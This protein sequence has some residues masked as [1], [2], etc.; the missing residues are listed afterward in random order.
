[1][2]QR[3]P[4][5]ISKGWR[6]EPHHPSTCPFPAGAT[7]AGQSEVKWGQVED[8]SPGSDRQRGR[9]L[10]AIRPNLKSGLA[11]PQR[12]ELGSLGAGLDAQ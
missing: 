4:R 7:D 2:P 3:R 8:L 1:M 11:E 5:K 12:D 9:R 10:P 6:V